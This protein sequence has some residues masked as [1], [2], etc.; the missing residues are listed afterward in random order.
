[1]D[2]VY[3]CGE[4]ARDIQGEKEARLIY[5]RVFRDPAAYTD[6]Y[7]RHIF[8]PRHFLSLRDGASILASLHQNPHD[9]LLGREKRPTLFYFAVAVDLEKRGRGYM[10]RLLRHAL[11]DAREKGISAVFLTPIDDGIYRKYGFSYVSDLLYYRIPLDR[12]RIS[13][14]WDL[15]EIRKKAGVLLLTEVDGADVNRELTEIYRKCMKNYH[16]FFERDENWFRLRREELAA[17]GGKGYL[18]REGNR[19]AGYFTAEP[20]DDTY[21][22]TECLLMD[23]KLAPL[24]LD[25]ASRQGDYYGKLELT[26][27]PGEDFGIFPETQLAMGEERRPVFMARILRPLDLFVSLRLPAGTTLRIRLRDEILPEND[28]I[29]RLQAGRPP[30]RE[31]EKTEETGDLELDIRHLA[32]LFSGYKSFEDL[33]RPGLITLCKE[34]KREAF[35]ALFPKERNYI[36]EYL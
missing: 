29:Y 15:R 19:T 32:A 17:C 35:G 26:A 4:T 1:M 7:F 11:R 25:L 8:D 14:D 5:E 20:E 2:D 34:E 12:L 30:L 16:L 22:I 24:V 28:G 27:P 13:S 3:V 31:E 18:I 10:D 9:F 6:F 36:R 33:L 23:P 21:R